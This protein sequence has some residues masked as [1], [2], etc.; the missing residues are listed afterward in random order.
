MRNWWAHEKIDEQHGKSNE[1]HG[2]IGETY[3]T[4]MNTME[5]SMKAWKIDESMDK[6]IK[7]IG[8]PMNNLGRTMNTIKK[9]KA[10]TKAKSQASRHKQYFSPKRIAKLNYHPQSDAWKQPRI[11]PF[12][13]PDDRQSSITYKMF[14]C[15]HKQSRV[16]SLGP[17]DDTK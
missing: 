15:R 11:P 14:L 17:I 1:R 16:L 10:N 13:G 2:K 6:L 12:P 3:G 4:P 9:S 5:K 8:T 7:I